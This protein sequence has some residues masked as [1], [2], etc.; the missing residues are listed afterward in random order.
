MPIKGFQPGG[1]KFVS[2]DLKM[3]YFSPRIKM[4]ISSADSP[5][6][7]PRPFNQIML[8]YLLMTLAPGWKHR[9]SNQGTGGEDQSTG[10]G[11][12]Q[13]R[14]TDQVCFFFQ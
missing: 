6:P 12:A 13:R 8:K 3:P 14:K 2:S 9:R 4:S 10:I 11:N 5:H 7:L 1:H